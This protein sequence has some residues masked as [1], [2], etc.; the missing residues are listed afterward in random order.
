MSLLKAFRDSTKEKVDSIRCDRHG[1]CMVK[2]GRKKTGEQPVTVWRCPPGEAIQHGRPTGMGLTQH[3]L[4]R[5]AALNGREEQGLVK[6]TRRLIVASK[7]DERNAGRSGQQSEKGTIG[8]FVAA[9]IEKQ[10]LWLRPEKEAEL[11]WMA[12]KVPRYL[13]PAIQTSERG[14]SSKRCCPCRLRRECTT[15]RIERLC[16]RS[17]S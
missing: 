12:R 15:G 16:G 10:F 11:N 14:V 4:Q 9:A 8:I 2:E 6:P 17:R 13:H 7:S 3:Y 5:H 1:S